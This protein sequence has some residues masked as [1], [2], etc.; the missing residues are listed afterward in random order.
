M[1]KIL[2]DIGILGLACFSFLITD[3]TIEVVKE[4]D[5]LMINL[6]SVAEDYKIAEIDGMIDDK[7]IKLGLNGL[8]VD[9][10][11]SYQKLKKIGYFNENMLVYKNIRSK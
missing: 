1:K 2:K 6:R 5:S 11:K 3:N 7:Y 4:K 8:E 10:D 9:I